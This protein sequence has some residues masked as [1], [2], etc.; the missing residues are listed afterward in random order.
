MVF[1]L[2]TYYESVC[3]II[4]HY[5]L[6]SFRNPLP[7]IHCRAEWTTAGGSPCMSS[8]A[9]YWLRTDATS[10][11]SLAVDGSLRKPLSSSEYYFM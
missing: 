2:G 11:L 3:A 5:L 6:Q 9:R 10:N 4:L 1:L 8:A 7:W